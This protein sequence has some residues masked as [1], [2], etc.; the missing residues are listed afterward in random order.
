MKK[1]LIGVLTFGTLS[2]YAETCGKISTLKIEAPQ[3]A[4]TQDLSVF[5]LDNSVSKNSIRG[6][7]ISA[8]LTIAKINGIEV[9]F[10]GDALR[11]NR[12]VTIKN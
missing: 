8:A 1:I 10:D 9:C 7:A 3:G 2:V 11:P 4:N 5:T 12:S 6:T